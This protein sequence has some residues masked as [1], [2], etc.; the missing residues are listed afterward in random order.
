MFECILNVSTNLLGQHIV[1]V[2]LAENSENGL[3]LVLTSNGIEVRVIVG[4]IS[5]LTTYVKIENQSHRRSHK[6]DKIRVERIRKFLF[7]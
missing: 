7:F 4:V 3:R 5:E 2:F 6:L 1:Q